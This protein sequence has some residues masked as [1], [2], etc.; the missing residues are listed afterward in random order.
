MLRILLLHLRAGAGGL[1]L[2]VAVAGRYPHVLLDRLDD[3]LD[4][5]L[6]LVVAADVL[7]T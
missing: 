7:E 2:V 4:V 3:L 6:E 5:L 1:R